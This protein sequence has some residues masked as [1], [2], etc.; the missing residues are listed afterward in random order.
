MN[1]SKK[2][3]GIV[4]AFIHVIK[5]WEELKM[6][7]QLLPMNLR[8]FGEPAAADPQDPPVDPVDPKES[9]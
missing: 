1:D 7:K 6:T 5:V 8:F 9:P 2:L 4:Q 3:Y